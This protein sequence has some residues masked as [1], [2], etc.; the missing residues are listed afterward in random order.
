MGEPDLLTGDHCI[1][2]AAIPYVL[3]D[4]LQQKAGQ[5]TA[6]CTKAALLQIKDTPA[7][8]HRAPHC[9]SANLHH[10]SVIACKSP[11]PQHRQTPQQASCRSC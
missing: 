10:V 8:L 5:T 2:V 1:E 3:G 7:T 6:L 9:N 11:P 4:D